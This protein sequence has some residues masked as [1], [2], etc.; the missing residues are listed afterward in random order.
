LVAAM[1]LQKKKGLEKKGK[2]EKKWE[3]EIANDQN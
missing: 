1:G 3:M 2:D